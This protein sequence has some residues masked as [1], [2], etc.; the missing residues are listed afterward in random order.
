MKSPNDAFAFVGR[1]VVP[2]GPPGLELAVVV[3]VVDLLRAAVTGQKLLPGY[4]A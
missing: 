3:V 4:A 1:V 2:S